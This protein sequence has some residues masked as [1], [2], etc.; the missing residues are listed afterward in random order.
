MSKFSAFMKQNKIQ[1]ENEKYAP[2]TTLLGADGTPLRWEFR[3]ITSKENEQLRD[4]CTT[5]VQVTGKPNQF[6]PKVNTAKY[7]ASMIV[8]ST[9]Y[10]DLYDSELQDSYN[11]KTPEDLLYAMV[12]DAGEYQEFTLWMQKFQGF[13]KSLDEKVEEAKN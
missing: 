7:I 4:A 13:N 1:K 3:H 6:R 2:T 11:V 9:V 5:E 8:T 10:P 12:D